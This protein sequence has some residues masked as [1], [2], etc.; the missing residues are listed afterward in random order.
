MLSGHRTR[1]GEPV[2]Y[3]DQVSEQQLITA[4]TAVEMFRNATGVNGDRMRQDLDELVDQDPSP[5][6]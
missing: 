1:G 2:D 4:A 3:E 6:G 5:R